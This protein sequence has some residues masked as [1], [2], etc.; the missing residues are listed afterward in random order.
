MDIL[1]AISL[2]RFKSMAKADLRYE[3]AVDTLSD[4]HN[5]TTKTRTYSAAR[6]SHSPRST[7]HVRGLLPS[8]RSIISLAMQS[9]S[10]IDMSHIRGATRRMFACEKAGLRSFRWRRCSGPLDESNPDP[11]RYVF[12]L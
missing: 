1:I 7:P 12:I 2:D 3:F 11:M 10:W 8:P 5:Q 9:L 4:G 6:P